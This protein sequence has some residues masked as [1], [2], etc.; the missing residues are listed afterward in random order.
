MRG[1][2][3]D[4]CTVIPEMRTHIPDMCTRIP[5]L[6][7]SVLA[8]IEDGSLEHGLQTL[9]V[10]LEGKVKPV[11]QDKHNLN[12]RDLDG[13]TMRQHETPHPQPAAGMT[14]PACVYG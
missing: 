5:G 6:Y 4:M 14:R 13:T 7:N 9:R 3:P 2:I 12:R 1:L 11:D 8:R 10:R